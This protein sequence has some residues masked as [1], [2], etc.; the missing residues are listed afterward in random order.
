[1]GSPGISGLLEF[2]EGLGKDQHML[3]FFRLV[4]LPKTS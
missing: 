1:M 4:K 3:V 2:Q